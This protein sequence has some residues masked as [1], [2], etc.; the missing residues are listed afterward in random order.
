LKQQLSHI[1][2]FICWQ[3][4]D[5]GNWLSLLICGVRLLNPWK[6]VVSH[7]KRNLTV[8][9]ENTLYFVVADAYSLKLSVLTQLMV[10]I[11]IFFY[12]ISS[13]KLEVQKIFH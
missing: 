10:E 3:S 1:G 4:I 6:T 7:L 13:P 9:D 12:H 11:R 8:M 2:V 5:A